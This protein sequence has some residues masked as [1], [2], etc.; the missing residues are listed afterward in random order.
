MAAPPSPASVQADIQLDRIH[1]SIS[2]RD[3]APSSIHLSHL[4]HPPT[5]PPPPPLA[6]LP[7]SSSCSLTV[8]PVHD[9]FCSVTSIHPANR[10]VIAHHTSLNPSCCPFDLHLQRLFL[11]SFLRS[12]VRI[13]IAIVNLCPSVKFARPLPLS[14][15]L[16]SAIQHFCYTIR[17]RMR[18]SGSK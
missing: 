16:Y 3:L 8:L 2:A 15:Y 1:P 5:P 10:S 17:A 12:L 14:I 18:F 6:L 13:I 11:P 4:N 7:M 9:F